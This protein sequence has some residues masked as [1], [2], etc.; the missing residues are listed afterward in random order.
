MSA[1]ILALYKKPADAAIFDHYYAH[2]HAPLAKTLPGLQSYTLGR[3]TEND[4]YYLVATLRFA[5]LDK[6]QAALAS[7]IGAATVADLENFAGAGVD[8]LTFTDEPA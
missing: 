1:T 4:P 5:S 3:G 7:A 6:L 2:K 8:I